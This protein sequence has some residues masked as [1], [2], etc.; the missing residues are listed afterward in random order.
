ML[1]TGKKQ[2][3]IL[4]LK[5]T[6]RIPNILLQMEKYYFLYITSFR[7]KMSMEGNGSEYSFFCLPLSRTLLYLTL[8]INISSNMT[9]SSHFEFEKLRKELMNELYWNSLK[10]DTQNLKYMLKCY[11]SFYSVNQFLTNIIICSRWSH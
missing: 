10:A 3:P 9:N 1:E 4:F 6:F 7:N 5:Y 2:A 11:F 8:S